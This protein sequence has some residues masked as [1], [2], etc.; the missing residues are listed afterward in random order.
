MHQFWPL[1][2]LGIHF[3]FT[4]F[5][6]WTE[7][8]PSQAAETVLPNFTV[9]PGDLMF[10]EVWVGNSGQSPS[11]SGLYAIAF[12]ED[13]RS[14]QLQAVL[15]PVVSGEQINQGRTLDLPDQRSLVRPNVRRRRALMRE[16]SLDVGV[17]GPHRP[18]VSR[19]RAPLE[20]R[21][22]RQSRA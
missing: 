2:L 18:C 3:D 17:T 22:D 11:L 1:C 14:E 4:T 20:L 9:T 16:H 10:T 15:A 8:L 21:C 6:G 13:I 7:F 5:Y 12:V 19:R